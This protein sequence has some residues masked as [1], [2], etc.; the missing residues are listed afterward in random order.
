MRL[1][2]IQNWNAFLFLIQLVTFFAF[3]HSLGPSFL[4]PPPPSPL[5]PFLLSFFLFSFLITF[6]LPF[7]SLPPLLSSTHSFSVTPFSLLK[8]DAILSAKRLLP[9][10]EMPHLNH[11]SLDRYGKLRLPWWS[12]GWESA[13][14]CRG[15][16]FDPLSGKIPYTEGQLSPCT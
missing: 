5:L 12:N 9:T 14:R 7:S 2:V 16:G 10:T 3:S 11:R 13:C 8:A 1:Y 6:I 15:H 4:S